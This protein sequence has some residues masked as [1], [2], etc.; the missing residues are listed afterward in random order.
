[1]KKKES[2]SHAFRDD[3]SELSS[4]T[5]EGKKERLKDSEHKELIIQQEF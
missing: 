4:K 2:S 3:I 5:N 1:M